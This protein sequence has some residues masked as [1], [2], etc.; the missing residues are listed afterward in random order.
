ML[1]KF[2]NSKVQDDD[3]QSFHC[4][5]DDDDEDDDDDDYEVKEFVSES[6]ED[7]SEPESVDEEEIG[8]AS[9]E[10]Q[11]G[12][13]PDGRYRQTGVVN[14]VLYVGFGLITL[15]LI[16][17]FVGIGDHGFK[18][19]ELR[20][21]GPSLIGCGILFCLLR[22]FFCS[23]P[24]CCQMCR[25]NKQLDEKAL[26]SPSRET[27]AEEPVTTT[28]GAVPHDIP[29]PFQH[30]NDNDEEEE[31]PAQPTSANTVH[32]TIPNYIEEDIDDVDELGLNVE[33]INE[34]SAKQRQKSASGS[35]T[36][37]TSS[38]SKASSVSKLPDIHSHA[39]RSASELVLNPATLEGAGD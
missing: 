17:T 11:L 13:S 35:A 16:L 38:Q 19:P 1:K 27:L 15:G 24:A 12:K 23:L 28:T 20:L 6:F 21:I 39:S 18:S 25:K 26:L 30:V 10:G 22:L 37:P 29:K 5:D 4:H 32:S 31:Q 14:I 7:E 34:G 36:R 2:R 3:V 8:D 33:Y 9:A